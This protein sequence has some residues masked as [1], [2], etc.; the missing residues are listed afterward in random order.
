MIRRFPRDVTILLIEHDMD[1]ALELAER[2][3]VFHNGR[4]V[5][6]G[7]RDEIRKDARVAEIYLGIDEA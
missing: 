4:V 1:V 7:P 5:T 3:I 2:L 6:A